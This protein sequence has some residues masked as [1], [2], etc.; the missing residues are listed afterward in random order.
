MHK[1]FRKTLPTVVLFTGFGLVAS[2]AATSPNL[3][4]DVLYGCVTPV[5]GN[6][7]KVSITP[8]TCPRKSSLIT[9]GA[10][11]SQGPAGIQGPTGAQGPA[12]IQGIQGLTGPAGAVGN[13]GL[14]GEVGPKGERGEAGIQ[15]D[16]GP[17][18]AAGPSD[19][20]VF[21]GTL[22]SCGHYSAGQAMASMT[23]PAGSYIIDVF[24]TYY[25]NY[26]PIPVPTISSPGKTIPLVEL[27]GG[28]W[29][30]A[31]GSMPVT[32][33]ETG[34]ISVNCGDRAGYSLQ[35]FTALK[36]GQINLATN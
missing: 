25:A 36:V 32:L 5:N 16:V 20:Y 30:K 6:L 33:S 13:Q 29:G 4:A 34:T 23:L 1:F 18:G 19:L 11:G 3:N 10:R 12:G 31:M 14:Q 22:A 21:S 35:R 24:T 28:N 8:P 9:W 17:Q 2:A 15:G 27:A 7:T 26:S